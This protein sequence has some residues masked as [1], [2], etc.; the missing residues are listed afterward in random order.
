MAGAREKIY[1]DPEKLNC[2]IVTCGGL[3][4]G[5]NDVIRTVT[6][7]LLWQYDVKKVYGFRY[8]YAGLS[9]HPPQPPL[10]L[11][12]DTVDEIHL[13]G[14]DILGSSRGH[15]DCGERSA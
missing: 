2:G 3:C 11:T 14:G 9:A 13:R 12:P 1:F 4:P 7:A 15:Q 6:L 5:L 10:E 8:G